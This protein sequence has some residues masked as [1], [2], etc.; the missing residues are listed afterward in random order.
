MATRQALKVAKTMKTKK[1][2]ASKAA[3]YIADLKHMGDEPEV[4]NK[5]LSGL[6]LG[7]VL[8]WYDYMCT[9]NDARD[10]INFF[11]QSQNR[12]NELKDLKKV[13]DVW[14]DLIAGWQARI[15]SRGG[16]MGPDGLERFNRR[17][18]EMLTKVNAKVDEID[19]FTNDD[20]NKLIKIK[21]KVSIQEKSADKVSDLIG[22]LDE[23]IDQN[24]WTVDVYDWLTKK[25]VPAIHAKRIGE[26]FKPIADEAAELNSGR[27]ISTKKTDP[28]LLEGY[29]YLSNTEVI[30]RHGF[31]SKLVNDCERFADVSKKQ[32]APRNK[33][34]ITAEKALKGFK[35]QTESKDYKV[36]S[37]KPEK[38][39]GSQ[40]LWTFNTKYKTLHVFYA[41][42]RGGLG[43]QGTTIKNY[44]ETKSK[45]FRMGRKTEDHLATALKGGKRA[46]TKLMQELKD[47]TLQHRCNENTILLRTEQ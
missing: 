12:L 21:S 45:G 23:L 27:R 5:P 1:V 16:N 33:K 13:P 39:I 26:F 24:G 20:E 11:L 7:M 2:R 18:K 38:L 8:N 22:E 47:C 25:Q 19:E 41:I 31:Y 3:Q 43:V 14:I 44:D 46:M 17:I 36:A 42:D 28:Q 34:P 40:E 35:Y 10:Y 15:L 30:K 9:R 37:V 29:A 32:K 6:E 4:Q